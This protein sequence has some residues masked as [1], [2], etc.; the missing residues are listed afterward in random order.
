MLQSQSYFGEDEL[1]IIHDAP[2][3]CLDTDRK[4]LVLFLGIFRYLTGDENPTVDL[5]SVTER[6][7][8]RRCRFQHV[9]NDR[10]HECFSL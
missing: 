6:G 5:D 3:L 9:V 8:G 7:N 2:G 4:R 1:Q 10:A